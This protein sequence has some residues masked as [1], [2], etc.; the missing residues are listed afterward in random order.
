MYFRVKTRFRAGH[1]H[2]ESVKQTE[3]SVFIPNQTS[4]FSTLSAH[5]GQAAA[6]LFAAIAIQ[7]KA[8]P[9]RKG[10]LKA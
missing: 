3:F 2:S 5:A 1:G 9:A 10:R 6:G 7:A 4:P 8:I